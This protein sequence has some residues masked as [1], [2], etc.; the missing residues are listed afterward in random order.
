[1]NVF[2]YALKMERDGE[3]YYRELARDAPGKALAAIFTRL[4]DAEARHYRIVLDMQNAAPA[5]ELADSDPLATADNLFAEL[6][7]QQDSDPFADPQATDRCVEAYRRAQEIEKQSM[8]F[9]RDKAKEAD[10]RAHRDRLDR[11]ADEEKRHCW[12]LHNIVTCVSR[13]DFSWIEFAEWNHLEAY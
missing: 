3:A 11:L 4:A 1:M 2:E 8:E 7:E 5:P 9:Y 13:P 6:K 12:I 10:D